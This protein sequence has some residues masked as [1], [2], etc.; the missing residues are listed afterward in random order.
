MAQGL[1]TSACRLHFLK[2][3]RVTGCRPGARRLLDDAQAAGI[4]VGALTND[5]TAFHDPEWIARIGIIREFDVLV[6]V[7]LLREGQIGRAHV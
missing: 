6:G 2:R 3:W 4:P 5:M 1:V 7:N